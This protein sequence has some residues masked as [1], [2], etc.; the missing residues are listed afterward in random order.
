MKRLL[1]KR[2]IEAV[3]RA[4][5]ADTSVVDDAIDTA[6]VGEGLV[7]QALDIIRDADIS[8]NA[9]AIFQVRSSIAR[10]RRSQ[11]DSSQPPSDPQRLRLLPTQHR[12]R[13]RRP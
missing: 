3:D 5:F 11:T 8:S 10:P 12:C 6:K 2:E 4:D 7:D 9:D 13:G 1:E